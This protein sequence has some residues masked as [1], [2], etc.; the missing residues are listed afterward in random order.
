MTIKKQVEELIENY[1]DLQRNPTWLEGI[2]TS[3]WLGAA[4]AA[5]GK[6]YYGN[7]NVIAPEEKPL[8]DL[9]VRDAMLVSPTFTMR[10]NGWEGFNIFFRIE[11]FLN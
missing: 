2:L 10:Y 11:F 3:T 4:L 9:K 7:G 8:P 6:I 1:N 5:D